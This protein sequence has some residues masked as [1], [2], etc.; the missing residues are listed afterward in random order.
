MNITKHPTFWTVLAAGIALGIYLGIWW[1]LIGG[2]A[3]VVRE[4]RSPNLD[5]L[6]LACGVAKI[7]FASAIGWL[8]A[9]ILVIPGV[10]MISAASD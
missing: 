4:V 10:A 9:C 6:A 8:S 2:I 5:A 7:L 3:T 1:A